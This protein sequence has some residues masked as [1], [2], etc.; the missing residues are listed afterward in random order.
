MAFPFFR[1]P[2]TPSGPAPRPMSSKPLAKPQPTP[3]APKPGILG[4]KGFRTF[5]QLRQEIKKP[6][7]FKSA[8]TYG[9]KFS[10]KERM[11]LVK[12]LQKTSGQS[13]GLS[14]KTMNIALKKMTKEKYMAG[15]KKD[16]KK[17]KELDQKIKYL[18]NLVKK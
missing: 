15:V 7:Y 11:D 4:E 17:A 1:K 10:A 13:Y 3:A 8:P 2:S 9:K 18:K 14:S 5:S 6:G 16:Y 12:T